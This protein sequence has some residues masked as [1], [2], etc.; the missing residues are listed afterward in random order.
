[1]WHILLFEFV[2]I[3]YCRVNLEDRVFQNINNEK[4]LVNGTF[5]MNDNKSSNKLLWFSISRWWCITVYI[6]LNMMIILVNIIRCFNLV[7]FF[8]ET[9]KTLHDNMFNAII[10]AKMHFFNT[11]S[12][13][14]CLQK[15]F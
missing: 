15:H 2:L 8:I 9:S 14:I 1:M 11:N 6:I 13:G 5:V 10:N 7:S 12:A 4:Y 3:L